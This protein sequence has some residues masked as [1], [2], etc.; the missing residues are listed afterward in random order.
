MGTPKDL[1]AAIVNALNEYHANES[2]SEDSAL[3]TI[4]LAAVKDRLAQDFSV[5]MMK[6]PNEECAEVLR[7]LWNK[8]KGGTQS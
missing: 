6:P 4:I 3:V 8:I 1:T 7:S 2:F 5:A